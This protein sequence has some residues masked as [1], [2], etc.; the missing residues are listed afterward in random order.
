MRNCDH[1]WEQLPD[2]SAQAYAAFC[3]FRDLPPSGRSLE[4]AY[5]VYLSAKRGGQGKGKTKKSVPGRWT[6][7]ASD[8]DWQGRATA[9]DAQNQRKALIRTA[10][11]RQK[12]IEAFVEND[13]R[14]SQGIQRIISKKLADQLQRDAVEVNASELRSLALGYDVSRKWLKELIGLLDSEADQ[15]GALAL[16]DEE[17]LSEQLKE[18]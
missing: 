15:L 8:Y 3:L 18:G 6:K 1:D 9:F 12:E 14:V 4:K 5:N 10:N 11:R 7:W 16:T 13:L 2:E 17:A